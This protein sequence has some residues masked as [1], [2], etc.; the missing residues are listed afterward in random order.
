[1]SDAM[2]SASTDLCIGHIHP[3]DRED[4]AQALRRP[5][6]LDHSLSSHLDL[7]TNSNSQPLKL[8]FACYLAYR[9]L[10]KHGSSCISALHPALGLTLTQRLSTGSIASRGQGH[11][12]NTIEIPQQQIFIH[13]HKALASDSNNTHSEDAKRSCNLAVDATNG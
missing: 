5:L 8:I 4:D 3:H 13:L 2:V 6:C 10:P 12:S 7:P 1:M 9:P 11:E